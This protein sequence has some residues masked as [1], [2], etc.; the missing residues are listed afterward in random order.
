MWTLTFE[1][2]KHRENDLTIGQAERIEDMTGETWLRIVP[3]RSAKHARSILV[4]MHADA[5]GESDDVVAARVKALKM[6]DF[7]KMYGTEDDDVPAMYTDG[8]PPAADAP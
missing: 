2:R 6:S 4:V 5:V 8:N 7:L 1:G 3:L